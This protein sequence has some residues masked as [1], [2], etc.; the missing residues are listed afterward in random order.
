[1]SVNSLALH[2]AL[3]E[4]TALNWH[5]HLLLSPN[6]QSPVSMKP[7]GFGKALISTNGPGKEQNKNMKS[8]L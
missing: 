2:K 1:M 5:S 6:E 7:S 8:L 4:I 3:T